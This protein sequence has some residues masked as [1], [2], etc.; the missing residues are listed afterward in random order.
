MLVLIIERILAYQRSVAIV[1]E[2]PGER[3][4][5]SSMSIPGAML[6][7]SC[8]NPGRLVRWN[9]RRTLYDKNPNAEIV[10]ELGYI[11]GYPV[12]ISKSPE[13]AKQLL[14]FKTDFDKEEMIMNTLAPFGPNV[15]AT[16]FH[17]WPRHRRVVQP[18]FTTSLYHA[19]WTE[20]VNTYY[21]CM[22][23]EKWEKEK[24]FI[25]PDVPAIT[26][27]LALFLIAKCGFGIHLAWNEQVGHKVN[28][29]SLP[30]CFNTTSTAVV[31]LAML[32][33]WLFGLP[34]TSLRRLNTA[35]QSLEVILQDLI[36]KRR[37]EGVENID[38]NAN[39]DIFSLLLKAN[40]DEKGSRAYLTDRE[41]VSNVFLLLLAGYETT[42]RSLAATLA[43]LACHPEEQE[44]AYQQIKSVVGSVR[45]PPYEDYERLPLVQG[46]FLEG[47]RMFP[48]APGM[49]RIAVRD[50]ILSVPTYDGK[51][52]TVPIK[53][54]QFIW[55]DW[56]GIGYNERVYSSA[57]TFLP[58][59]WLDPE[60]EPLINFSY[61]PRVCLGKKFAIT[62][63]VGVLTLLLRDYRIELALKQGQTS[64]QW[65]EKW[66][67]E[68]QESKIGFGPKR[69]PLKFTRRAAI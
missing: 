67:R 3:Y 38:E 31:L 9:K 30:D 1:R 24:S 5:F 22:T 46:C 40:D 37:T 7:S 12:L 65:R 61:G 50:T 53:A 36:Y 33:Q 48:S 54:G 2:I 59:R 35:R 55:S 21:D 19:V 6:P 23:T 18:G 41:L 60:T 20:T 39:K 26:S 17:D 10:S 4:P 14:G 32:P 47:L 27:K 68:G 44:K 13:V 51:T 63:A 49:I 43:L 16:N 42:S 58:A 11:G 34:L 28:G 56:I 66:E 69:F 15:F 8:W 29:M 62:E 52:R 64:K 45:D 25:M 57:Y